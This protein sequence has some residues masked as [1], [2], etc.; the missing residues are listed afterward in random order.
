[1]LSECISAKAL[2]SAPLLESCALASKAACGE[3][4]VK[5]VDFCKISG[6]FNAQEPFS[7]L[8]DK[9]TKHFPS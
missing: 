8:Q 1:M 9:V 4:Q 3:G 5:K 7:G 2:I 6:I